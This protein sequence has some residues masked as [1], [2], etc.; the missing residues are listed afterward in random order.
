MI[1]L[2]RPLYARSQ[3]ELAGYRAQDPQPCGSHNTANLT[4]NVLIAPGLQRR[5][6]TV[7]THIDSHD[8][9]QGVTQVSLSQVRHRSG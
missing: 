1:G 3:N 6:T 8:F 4:S 7:G 9:N 2:P 5:W